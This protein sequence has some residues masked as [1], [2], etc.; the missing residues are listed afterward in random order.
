MS[1]IGN[2][3]G[4]NNPMSLGQSLGMNPHV[5]NLIDFKTGETN[6]GFRITIRR[7]MEEIAMM[8]RIE[9]P[10]MLLREIKISSI[11]G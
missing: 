10:I 1:H 8:A 5:M 6:F 2:H 4:L 7:I 3:L 9:M 11:E